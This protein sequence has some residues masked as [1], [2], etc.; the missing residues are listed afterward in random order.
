MD[1][2]HEDDHEYDSDFIN[3]A[4]GSS[5]QP[6]ESDHLSK[7]H[8]DPVVPGVVAPSAM[9]T[10]QKRLNVVKSMPGIE[11]EQTRRVKKK[12]SIPLKNGTT[13]I[14]PSRK[15]DLLKSNIHLY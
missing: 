6:K 8:E 15:S 11:S 10:E 14:I 5:D 2:V 9:L 7:Q 3:I 12:K 1:S 13:P 4:E